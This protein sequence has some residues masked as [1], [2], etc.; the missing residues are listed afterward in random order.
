MNVAITGHQN[1]GTPETI[2][3]VAFALEK[4]LSNLEITKG[5]TCLAIG[6]DQLFAQILIKKGVP[7]VAVLACT[8]IETSFKYDE[9]KKTFRKLL[10][11]ASETIN[12]PFLEPSQ[13]AYFEAGKEVVDK[14]DLVIA[15]WNG[16]PAQ[17]LGGTGDIVAYALKQKKEVLHINL[18]DRKI[19]K[20]SN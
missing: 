1:L 11:L 3:W 6:A 4:V 2:N 9:E 20:L 16:Q 10:G 13:E 15:V 18:V 8:L 5:Y 14:T 19:L 12:L 17:G 7:Y